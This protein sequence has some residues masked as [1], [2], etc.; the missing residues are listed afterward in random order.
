MSD[1]VIGVGAALTAS[2]LY[3]V[4]VGLQA[5][6]A[7]QVPTEHSLQVSL[8][9]RLVRRPL[10]LLGAATG[11]LGWVLQAVA[12]SVAPLTLVEPI[13]ATSL[14]FVLLLER[15]RVRRARRPA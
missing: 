15:V 2:A 6:E 12:L 3:A 7:R 8:L 4:A 5:L 9:T 10:W 1:T 11:F 13:L 14:A